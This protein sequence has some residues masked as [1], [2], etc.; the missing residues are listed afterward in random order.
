MRP[1]H[2]S[3][4]LH[5]PLALVNAD[6]PLVAIGGAGA[7]HARSRCRAAQSACSGWMWPTPPPVSSAPNN[8][9][10]I[11]QQLRGSSNPQSA[12]WRYSAVRYL[13]SAGRPAL[14]VS[15]T[16]PLHTGL[17]TR[18][19]WA[20]DFGTR[21]AGGGSAAGA[22]QVTKQEDRRQSHQFARWF[23][24]CQVREQPT[25]VALAPTV[26]GQYWQGGKPQMGRRSWVV[27][28]T[29]A[30]TASWG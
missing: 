25:S 23:S 14:R 28:S 27:A 17:L 20:A 22:L 2:A 6:F 16:S 15:C 30:R 10:L 13:R 7:R 29:Q 21:Q 18:R 5:M 1:I 9:P 12:F 24:W 11:S 4:I 3:C 19:V 26:V 8:Q